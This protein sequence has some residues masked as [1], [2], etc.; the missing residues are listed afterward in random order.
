MSC[1]YAHRRA[2]A[3]VAEQPDRDQY[4]LIV[5][6]DVRVAPQ[7]NETWRSSSFE[8]HCTKAQTNW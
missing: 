8:F 4:Y 7:K 3:R 2:Y 1:D 6:D 5:E